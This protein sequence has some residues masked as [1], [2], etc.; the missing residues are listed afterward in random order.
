MLA[1]HEVGTLVSFIPKRN[2]NVL[3]LSNLH[4]N[5]KID[6]NT[7]KPDIIMDYNATKGGVDA[8]ATLCA[9]YNCARNTERWP[10]VIFYSLVNVAGINS[11]VIYNINNQSENK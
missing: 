10:M 7:Q 5:D 2:K 3:I 6:E 11:Y 9:T 4:R 8:L 1:F